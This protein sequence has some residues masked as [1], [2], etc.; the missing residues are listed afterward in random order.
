[1]RIGI[2]TVIVASVLSIDVLGRT[3]LADFS[4]TWVLETSDGKKV[5]GPAQIMTIQQTPGEIAVESAVTGTKPIRLMYRLDGVESPNVVGRSNWTSTAA[6]QGPALVIRTARVTRGSVGETT[7]NT[8]E[9][10]TREDE[11]TLVKTTRLL[12]SQDA[13]DVRL[14]FR[15]K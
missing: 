5:E 6:W 10:W 12:G 4:G 15:R 8:L 14:V 7:I 9:T 3:Q 13:K 11:R 1:M 2:L